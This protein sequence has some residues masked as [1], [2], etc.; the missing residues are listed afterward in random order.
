MNKDLARQMIRVNFRCSRELQELM[1]LLK[2]QLSADEYK[3][4]AK[5]IAT[6]IAGIGDALTNT[7][8]SSFPE[9][10]S[11]IETSLSKYGRFI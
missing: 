4:H 10:E 3:I 9:L 11:E 8:I 6:A 1:M 5:N 2:E 7:A